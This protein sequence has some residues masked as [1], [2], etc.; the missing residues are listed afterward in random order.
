MDEQTREDVFFTNLLEEGSNMGIDFILESPQLKSSQGEVCTEQFP[1]KTQLGSIANKQT[2]GVKFTIEE[3]L[4][5]VSAWLNTSMDPIAGNQQKHNVYWEKIYEYCQKEKTF[6]T[7]CSANSL[8]HRWST[9]Q[10][11]T[12][13]F[14]G[15][16]A[17]IER[18]NE[19]GLNEQDKVLL[20]LF[21]LS[22]V[23]I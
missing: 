1:S 17:Q 11:K 7:N 3:D 5:I 12:N 22:D 13:K 14:C 10:L 15:Y 2:R 16:L 8:M 6:R 9:I 20:L 18:R 4:L 23:K 19:S 21:F